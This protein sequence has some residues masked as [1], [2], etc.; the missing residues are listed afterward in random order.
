MKKRKKTSWSNYIEKVSHREK[1]K[2]KHL[3]NIVACVTNENTTNNG[4]WN[5][6]PKAGDKANFTPISMMGNKS[7]ETNDPVLMVIHFIF[8]FHHWTQTKAKK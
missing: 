3:T 2:K 8:N 7:D 1:K 6:G 4:N 5:D